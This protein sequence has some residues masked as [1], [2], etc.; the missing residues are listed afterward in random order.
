MD[1]GDLGDGTPL[2]HHRGDE[3]F[4]Q[5]HAWSSVAGGHLTPD[6]G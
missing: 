3:P 2:G 4:A 6:S 1:D 5:R